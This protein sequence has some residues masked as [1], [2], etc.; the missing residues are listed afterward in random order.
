MSFPDGWP[1]PPIRVGPP[2][3]PPTGR[4]RPREVTI[5]LEIMD[6][7][8]QVKR[9]FLLPFNVDAY[10][11]TLNVDWGAMD[12]QAMKGRTSMDAQLQ[13]FLYFQI[14]IWIEFGDLEVQRNKTTASL[15][16]ARQFVRDV[17]ELWERVSA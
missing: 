12:S 10:L 17:F 14:T 6:A 8:L 13:P 2:P 15:Q 9:Q 4:Q 7:E 5:W 1:A 11:E 16:D 3:A